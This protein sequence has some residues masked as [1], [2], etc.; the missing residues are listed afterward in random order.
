[1][2]CSWPVDRSCLPS[3]TSDVDKARQAAAED[4]AVA[5]LWALSGRQYGVCPTITRPCPTPCVA[6]MGGVLLGGPG[7]FPIWD[8]GNWR[9]VTCGCAGGNCTRSGPGVVHLPGPVAEV[10]RVVIGGHEVLPAEYAVEGDFLYRRGGLDWPTQDLARPAGEVGTWQVEYG[11]GVPV[12][13]GVGVL[14]GTLAL[15]FLNACSG[16][17]CRLPRR[18]QSVSRQGVNFQMVDPTDI[19]RS[20]L[21]GIPEID[22]WLSSVNPNRLMGAPRVR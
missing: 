5:I 2:T 4:L 8:D 7:W 9:N 20:G 14:V 21:T 17:K 18:V 11:R 22:V 15:E 16:G 19:Y 10:T 13:V 1:M 3:A 12:P 6:P